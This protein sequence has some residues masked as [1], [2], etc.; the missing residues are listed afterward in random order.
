MESQVE[1]QVTEKIRG[2]ASYTFTM[3]Q[4]EATGK[5]LDNAPEHL[6]KLNLT[7]PIYRDWLF[8]GGEAQ[9]VGERR[10]ADEGTLARVLLFNVTLFS[11]RLHDAWEFSTSVYNVLGTSYRVDSSRTETEG[12]TFRMKAIHKF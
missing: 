7:S 1:G 2:R 5:P 9:Y 11:A 6:A 3:T 8:V 12:R 4:D 10:M